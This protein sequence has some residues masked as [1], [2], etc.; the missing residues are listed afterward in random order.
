MLRPQPI[1][2]T[3]AL[4]FVATLTLSAAEPR[5]LQLPETI[6][7]QTRFLNRDFVVIAHK[8]E[9]DAIK[10][11]AKPL[12][13]LVYLHGAG[14]RGDDIG[15]VKK[16][17]AR[18]LPGMKEH[19]GEPCLIVAPQCL[20]GTREKMGIWQ[21]KD[22]DLL[23]GHLKARFPVDAARV[24]LT[25]NSMGGFGSWAWAGESPQHFAAVAPV[26]GGLGYGG[27]K[28]VFPDLKRWAN[29]LR[30]IPVWAF[31]GAKDPVVPAERS[32][33]MVKLI[34]EQGGKRAKLTIHSDEGHGAGKVVFATAEF[35]EWLFAQRRP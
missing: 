28:D 14:G 5:V 23:L 22:L 6:H 9:A 26:V 33:R 1:P 13:L 30:D 12:P 20:K 7:Q 17:V 25:G 29:N 32:E 11:D 34:R 27:P 8:A 16:N 2:A 24:Y 4:L 3:I 21:P 10:P 35:Y 31:H 15:K 18:L 19:V